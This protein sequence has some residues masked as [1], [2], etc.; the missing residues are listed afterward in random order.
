IV[1]AAKQMHTVIESL[2][3]GCELCLPACPVDC[4]HLT[5][6][7]PGRSGWAAWSDQQAEQSRRLYTHRAERL[8]M[9]EAQEAQRLTARKPEPTRAEA[10][11][12]TTISQQAIAEA[13]ARARSRQVG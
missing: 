13:L 12:D 5:I 6:S 2:C 11:D 8:R 3:T 4:I 10:N 7:T 1:G 9:T